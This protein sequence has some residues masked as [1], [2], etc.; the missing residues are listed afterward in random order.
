MALS[1]KNKKKD[2][3]EA[4]M[5][6][7]YKQNEM[8]AFKLAVQLEQVIKKETSAKAMEWK[9]RI[10]DI[11][12]QIQVRKF[13]IAV[14]GEFNRG[15][16]SFINVLLG[17]R[18]LPE[19][20]L[21]STATINRVTYGD[22]PRAYLVMKHDGQRSR[23]IPVEDLSSYITKLTESSVKAASEI[24]EAVVEYPTMF[25]YNDVDLIDTPGMNDMED[26]NALTVSRLE[27][28]D[29]AIVAVNAQYPYSETENQFVV[30]LLESR[31]VCQII[32]VITHFDMIRDREKK[33]LQDY[34]YSQIPDSIFAELNKKYQSDAKIFVKYHSIFDDLHIFGVSSLMAMEALETNDMERYKASG[35]LQLSRELPEVILSSKSVNMI[36][37]IVTMLEE[38]IE[39][40]KTERLESKDDW[41]LW[42]KIKKN[43]ADLFHM[44]LRDLEECAEMEISTKTLQQE[45]EQQKQSII[46]NM[47]MSLGGVQEI[48]SESIHLAILPVMQEEFR[49]V[50]LEYQNLRN[51][52]LEMGVTPKWRSLLSR[53]IS[54]LG[55]KLKLSPRMF[56]Q[57][58]SEY[59]MFSQLPYQQF[60]TARLHSSSEASMDDFT[61]CWTDSPIG[62]V[63]AA[64]GNQSVLP[65]LQK[66]VDE[67][68]QECVGRTESRLKD[69]ISEMLSFIRKR[70][71]DFIASIDS[72]IY[73]KKQQVNENSFLMDDVNLLQDRKSV[74]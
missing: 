60:L 45:T 47:L 65:G 6:A 11:Q 4:K 62:A 44:T 74:V 17:K 57:L 8:H 19:D 58:E 25:C 31:K 41:K 67:S 12:Q 64:S 16:S 40:Y 71:D 3:K 52:I 68:L 9:Q 37:N 29:L 23:E 51:Q 63:L 56:T 34:L 1:H 18:I 15:K 69:R 24:D 27:D 70:Q 28:I 42:E 13:R 20:V 36:D 7:S 35:F 5:D 53:L 2:T 50:N 39:E 48:T 26:M 32:F 21:A 49:R 22:K 43:C 66:V 14:V 33:R 30:K 61:F 54:E 59:K 73:E 55:D 10:T 46:Q 38:I 72:A